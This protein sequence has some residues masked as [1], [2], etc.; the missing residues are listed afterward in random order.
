MTLRL[1]LHPRV[2]YLCCILLVLTG[3]ACSLLSPSTP[4]REA[5]KI[6]STRT[7]YPTFTPTAEQAAVPIPPT[8]TATQPPTA[9]PTAA[10]PPPTDT[11]L[12][13]PTD[14][15]VPPPPTATPAPPPPTAPPP[16]QPPQPTP[17][18]QPA[19]GAH[20]VIGK[21]TFRD[22][23]N[24]YGVGEKVFV[25]IEATNTTANT[26]PFG[27]LGLATSTGGFQ[28]SWSGSNIEAGKTFNWEDG[29]AFS[30]SGT[31]K[32]WLSIC[33]SSKDVCQGANGDWE[34][35]EPGLDVVVK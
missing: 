25:K 13:A 10:P 9:P 24:T 26:L 32:M 34:R 21:I 16:T 29:L 8:P 22:G 31:Y 28:T 2:M 27:V 30:A 4:E 15:P 17:P 14:T 6:V 19:A 5:T 11:P 7:P 23:R 1:P 35:F 18:P 3:L 20:G 33:F 12:P